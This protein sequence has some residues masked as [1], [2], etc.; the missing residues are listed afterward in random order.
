MNASGTPRTLRFHMQKMDPYIQTSIRATMSP[1]QHGE[2]Y[3]LEDGS[4]TDTLDCGATQASE[5]LPI[6][7][8]R[9]PNKTN[10]HHRARIYLSVITQGGAANSSGQ[11][12]IPG[13][14]G[15]SPTTVKAGGRETRRP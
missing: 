13:D 5:F 15:T 11:T 8:L 9:P 14:P 12:G 7:P 3:V 1:Y 6:P 10:Y 4:E 2:V